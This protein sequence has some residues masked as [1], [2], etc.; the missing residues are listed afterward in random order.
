MNA[1]SNISAGI[2]QYKWAIVASFIGLIAVVI[3]VFLTTYLSK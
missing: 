2:R 1:D 3:A